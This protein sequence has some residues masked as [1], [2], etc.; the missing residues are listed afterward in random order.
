MDGRHGAYV[1]GI[2]KEW[3][4]VGGADSY[5]DSGQERDKSIGIGEITGISGGADYSDAA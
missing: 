5:P 2:E 3:H 1:G 4:T